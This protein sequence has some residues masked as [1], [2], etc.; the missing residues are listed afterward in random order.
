[1][2]TTKDLTPEMVEAFLQKVDNLENV[3]DLLMEFREFERLCLIGLY[4]RVYRA[5][6]YNAMSVME[7]VTDVKR[8]KIKGIV[9][10]K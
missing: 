2:R 9:H 5:N 7:L 4:D 3:D 10:K 6:P 8:T 1:M